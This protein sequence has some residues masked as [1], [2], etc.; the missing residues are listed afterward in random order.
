MSNSQRTIELEPS[1]VHQVESQSQD[2]E[3][4]SVNLCGDG[5]TIEDAIRHAGGMG[6]F[7][8]LAILVY[9]FLAS[10]GSFSLYTMTYYEL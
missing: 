8:W 5:V 3:A 10:S 7:Q 2:T 1:K 4:S 9:Q 6:R